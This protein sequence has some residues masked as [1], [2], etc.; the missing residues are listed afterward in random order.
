MTITKRIAA[1]TTVVLIAMTPAAAH[2]HPN[3]YGKGIKAAP[4]TSH[5]LAHAA[6]SSWS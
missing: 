2:A 5:V 3:P 1:I 6:R 4:K